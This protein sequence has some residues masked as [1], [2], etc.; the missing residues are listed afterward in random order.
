MSNYL[1]AKEAKKLALEYAVKNA[2]EEYLKLMNEID[3]KIK[4]GALNI[5]VIDKLT[6]GDRTLLKEIHEF[7]LDYKYQTNWKNGE[8]EI[9][10]YIIVKWG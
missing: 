2:S 7:E 6:N 9:V 3:L 4:E 5:M 1:T 10:D 8:P